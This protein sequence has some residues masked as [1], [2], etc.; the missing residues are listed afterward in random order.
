[1]VPSILRPAVY[2]PTQNVAFAFCGQKVGS[3]SSSF[4]YFSSLGSYAHLL[5][6]G[7]A[8]DHGIR[9]VYWLSAVLALHAQVP[10][11]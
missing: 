2:E 10:G 5:Q 8:F 9:V 6:H 4:G 1:M 11:F 3:S 7:V